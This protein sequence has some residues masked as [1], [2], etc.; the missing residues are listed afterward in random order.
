MVSTGNIHVEGILLTDFTCVCSGATLG[1]YYRYMCVDIPW[2]L[3]HTHKDRYFL[4]PC[5][6]TKYEVNEYGL[7]VER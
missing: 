7:L 6:S 5:I 3:Y 4:V 1:Q 2:Y